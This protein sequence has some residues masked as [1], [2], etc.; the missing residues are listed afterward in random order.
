MGWH[1]NTLEKTQDPKK[2]RQEVAKGALLRF[3]DRAADRA[4]YL[5][6]KALIRS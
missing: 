6:A 3:A 4:L 5:R 2:S 1:E